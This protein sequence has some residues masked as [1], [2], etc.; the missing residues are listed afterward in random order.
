MDHEG[1]HLLLGA[2]PSLPDPPV[3]HRQG[4]EAWGCATVPQ[5][6]EH[7]LTLP[8]TDLWVAQRRAGAPRGGRVTLSHPVRE[9]RRRLVSNVRPLSDRILVKR[10]DSESKTKGGIIIPDTAKEKPAE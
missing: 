8:W 7:P 4:R 10:V 6:L 3:G 9:G 2:A 1:K 5:L